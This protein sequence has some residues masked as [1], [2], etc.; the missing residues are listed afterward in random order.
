MKHPS[1]RRGPDQWQGPDEL[2]AGFGWDA[3]HH[4]WFYGFRLALRTDLGS[5]LVR[6]W[7]LVPAAV[8]ERAVGDALLAGATPVG[9][10][11]D[12]GFVSRAWAE[13]YEQRGTHV[14]VAHSR[15]ERR[16]LP[17]ALRRPVAALRNRIET[18]LGEIT[19]YL[20]LARHGAKTFWGLLARAAATLLTHTWLRLG[21]L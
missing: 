2:R 19:E 4:E 15:A 3:A 6:A 14:V 21:Y 8:D 17:K 12:R 20:G 10:L 9:L 1:R 11:L 18:S 13:G 5:R 7:G 16:H